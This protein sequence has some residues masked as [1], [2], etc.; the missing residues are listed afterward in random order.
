MASLAARSAGDYTFGSPES[1][2]VVPA[3]AP[4]SPP[5]EGFPPG[6][7]HPEGFTLSSFFLEL[8]SSR[9]PPPQARSSLRPAMLQLHN[10]PRHHFCQIPPPPDSSVAPLVLGVRGIPATFHISPVLL[11]P[12]RLRLRPV[13]HPV[14]HDLHLGPRGASLHLFPGAH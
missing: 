4:V 9:L 3:A 12:R 14:P 2:W 13:V 6:G 8:S 7:F 10:R 1:L 11:F 5:L